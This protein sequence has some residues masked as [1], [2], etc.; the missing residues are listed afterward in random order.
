MR[1]VPVGWL[2]YL[3]YREWLGPELRGEGAMGYL[4]MF[5]PAVILIRIRHPRGISGQ[6]P[7]F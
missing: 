3:A 7:L 2:K 1:V 5:E 6:F 4:T